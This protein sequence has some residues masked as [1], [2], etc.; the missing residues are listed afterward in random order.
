MKILIFNTLYFPNV[1]GGAEKSVKSLAES[2]MNLDKNVVIVSTTSKEHDYTDY[3]DGVKVYYLNHKNIYW[4]FE[5]KKHSK[6]SRLI[7]HCIDTYN[8]KLKNKLDKILEHENPSIVHTNNLSGFSV[9]V[10]KLAKNHNIKIVHTL[11][12][13]YLLC[14]N[15]TM[16]KNA[17]NCE[18]Q[19]S[20]CRVFSINKRILSKYVDGLVG[21]SR[22][23]Q[24]QHLENNFFPYVR[25]QSIIGNDVGE[26][27]NRRKKTDKQNIKFGFIG[28]LNLAKG[29]GKLLSTFQK[30]DNY[31]NWSLIIAG[32]GKEEF[33]NQMKSSYLNDRIS[34]IGRVSPRNFFNKIDVLIVPSLW[35]EPFGRV[36]VEGIKYGTYVLGSQRGG[37]T[38]LLKK[39]DLFDPETNE[40]SI[41]IIEILT[42]KKELTQRNNY[43]QNVGQKY[44][45][46]Y[47][48]VLNDN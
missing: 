34:F 6:S 5:N 8:A 37:I 16:Y 42:G 19:C 9:L 12:D 31:E 47:N 10:W 18:N 1:I 13:Y 30:L 7:W 20:T 39:E 35:Q 23:I 15:S 40:L 43:S 24:I 36:V 38:E 22:Y 44:V 48:K 33:E 29:L 46:F 11:R 14:P 17:K 41:K 21:I 25:H 28:Q 2:L 3:V 45:D 32:E 4:G 26:I 27:K